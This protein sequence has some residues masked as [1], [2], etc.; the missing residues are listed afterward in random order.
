MAVAG[1][2]TVLGDFGDVIF[3]HRGVKSRFFRKD[4]EYFVNTQGHDGEW[5]DFRVVYTFG[6]EPLQQYLLELPRGR[7]QSFTVAWDTRPKEDGGQRWFSLDPDEKITPEDPLHWSGSLYNWNSRCASC[8]S[9]GLRK[10]YEA[11][12]DSY[13][14][15]WNDVDVS[16]QA[17]HGPGEA[18]VAWARDPA[19]KSAEKKHRG[20]RVSFAG[21]AKAEIEVCAPCHSRR[22]A[23]SEAGDAGAPLLDHYVPQLL[24][25]DL[26]FSDGQ[27]MEEVYVYGS[28]AQSKMHERGVRCTDCHDPHSTRLRV[29]GNGLCTQCHNSAGMARFPSLK[30]ASYDSVEHHHHPP[31]STAAA[32][33]SCHMPART[34]M[35]VDDRRDHS[36]RLPRPDLT[37]KLGA[38]NACNGCHTDQ[39]PRWAAQKISQWFGAQRPPHWSEVAAAAR[40]GEPSAL[41]PAI[42]L[43]SRREEPAIV[44][45]TVLESLPAYGPRGWEAVANATRDPDPLVRATAA[46]LLSVL[47][48]EARAAPG[49]PL[50]SDPYRAVRI[51]AAR[52]L[53]PIAR[54]LPPPNIE[55][56]AQ[57][58]V[59]YRN[60]QVV[61]LDTPEAHLNLGLLNADV[62]EIDAAIDEY[63]TAIRRGPHFLPAYVNL[64]DVYR[65]Q[66]READ[67]EKTL[68]RGLAVDAMNA[69]VRHA[70]GL[71]LV[72]Q[73]RHPEA[74]EELR[75]SAEATPELVRYSYV[76]AIALN[77][78]GRGDEAVVVLRETHERHPGDRD[79]LAALASVHR[80]RGELWEAAAYARKLVELAPDAPALRQMAEQIQAEAAAKNETG[81]EAP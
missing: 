22:H 38:P 30:R 75:R 24:R 20:L 56:L 70:L 19:Q 52:S 73:R 9:T 23:I 71:S 2:T 17:C 7:L 51:E 43:T 36:F 68:R 64:A 76:Y 41:T 54:E 44:R 78:S 10:R 53:V 3:E 5:R 80:E 60:A 39:P 67:C 50:L 69:S 66:G 33:V 13:E 11:Q 81:E 12:T 25:E 46:G 35:V 74:L 77:S 32:C 34:Y 27:I 21:P 65:L 18:H 28:F 63:E 58:L 59:E 61:N 62:G 47:P 55:A 49:A 31:G 37:E 57:G 6:V 15:T 8:H 42:A 29:E 48:P 14:T 26:Y 45:A 16:C 1:E 72:R 4:G 79:V 40:R